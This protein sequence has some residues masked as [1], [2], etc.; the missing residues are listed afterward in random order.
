[1]TPTDRRDEPPHALLAIE[2]AAGAAGLDEVLQRSR[3]ALGE[4]RQ[5]AEAA[6]V[7]RS[8]QGAVEQDVE[9]GVVERSELDPRSLMLVRLAALAAVDAPPISYLMNLA[10]ASDVGVARTVISTRLAD[11][12]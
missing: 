4:R 9:V 11:E 7:D 5:L 1:M 12:T 2:D 8:F 6:I 3:P 10:V